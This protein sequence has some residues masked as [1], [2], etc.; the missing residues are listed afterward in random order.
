MAGTIFLFLLAPVVFF[1]LFS[2]LHSSGCVFQ[3]Q[4]LFVVSL[5]IY[6]LSIAVPFSLS[7]VARSVFITIVQHVLFCGLGC[8]SRQ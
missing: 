1:S 7:L 2:C 5:H 8:T 4:F 6:N 3:A